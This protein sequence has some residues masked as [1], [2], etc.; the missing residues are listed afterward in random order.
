MGRIEELTCGV[1]EK[2]QGKFQWHGEFYG[3]LARPL[4]PRLALAA[5]PV[6]QAV[7]ADCRAQLVEAQAKEDAMCPLRSKSEAPIWWG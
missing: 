4:S 6:V 3:G 5:V 2:S 1:G 7:V